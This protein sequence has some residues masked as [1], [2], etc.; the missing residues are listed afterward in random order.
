MGFLGEN[1]SVSE[2]G[3]RIRNS[4]KP[5][6]KQTSPGQLNA[7]V[8]EEDIKTKNWS[9]KWKLESKEDE[10]AQSVE[11]HGQG[12]LNKMSLFHMV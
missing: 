11:F 10:M 7:V 6:G 5:S 9:P 1:T 12:T 3:H 4:F 8:C 2:W